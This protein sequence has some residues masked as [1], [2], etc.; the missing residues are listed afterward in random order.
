MP[1]TFATRLFDRLALQRA[2]RSAPQTLDPTQYPATTGRNLGTLPFLFSFA[3]VATAII[4]VF[5]GFSFLLLSHSKEQPI[6]GSGNRDPG[7]EIEPPR[8]DSAPPPDKDAAPVTVQAGLPDTVTPSPPS[9]LA[10]PSPEARQVLPPEGRDASPANSRGIAHAKNTGNG[11]H[12]QNGVRKRWAGVSRPG[13]KSLPAP[14]LNPPERAWRWI[15]R[16]AT[17]VLAAL[18][19]PPLP[20]APR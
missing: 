3:V 19:P 16:S 5:F 13:S 20:R 12:P 15:V 4:V 1:R 10:A 18:S 6:A 17:G 11:R 2:S 14:S 8:V 9:A 7:V